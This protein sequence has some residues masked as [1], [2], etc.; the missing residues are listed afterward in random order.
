[1]SILGYGWLL[2]AYLRKKRERQVNDG[3]GVIAAKVVIDGAI[4]TNDGLKSM[5]MHSK[6]TY[7][8]SGVP[9][10]NSEQ[11]IFIIYR[12]ILYHVCMTM[13]TIHIFIHSDTADVVTKMR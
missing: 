10:N 1:M 2:G 13:L 7:N 12:T 6:L 11:C 8:G 3:D 9:I 5:I 4:V